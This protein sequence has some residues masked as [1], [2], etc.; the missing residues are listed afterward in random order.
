VDESYTSRINCLTGVETLSSELSI[1][2]VELAPGLIVD[3][4]LNSA[5]NIAKRHMS[6]W[7]APNR[8]LREFSTEFSEDVREQFFEI[9]KR[10][11]NVQHFKS[12]WFVFFGNPDATPVGFF[13]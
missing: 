12:S 11:R 9:T 1:R 4:D 7:F 6:R 8:K 13:T 5:T 10:M 2:E 3:R